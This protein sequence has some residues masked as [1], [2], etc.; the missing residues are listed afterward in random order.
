M[1][2]NQRHVYTSFFKKYLAVSCHIKFAIKNTNKIKMTS[3]IFKICVLNLKVKLYLSMYCKH[4][5]IQLITNIFKYGANLNLQA[6]IY[7]CLYCKGNNL[8]ITDS[9]QLK[10]IQLFEKCY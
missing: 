2:E 6:T 1:T 7:T 8:Q 10:G 4:Q 9:L 3:L 5:K